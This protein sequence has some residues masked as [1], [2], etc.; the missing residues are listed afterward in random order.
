MYFEGDRTTFISKNANDPIVIIKNTTDD[1]NAARLRL[2]KVRT[3]NGLV[4][5]AQDADK[6]GV[7]E[8]VSRDDGTPD[9]QT[10]GKIVTK[11]ADATSTEESG[12]VELK[13]ATHDG[14]LYNGF[15]LQGGSVAQE[16]DVTIANG[17]ASNTT[18]AG[19]LI[20]TSD[21]TVS[22]TTTTI[23][24]AT[25]QVEDKN[26]VLN[27]NASSDT[28]GTADGAGITIQDAVDAS[29][30]ASLTW[31]SASDKFQFSHPLTVTGDLTVNGE[32]TLF[33]S[34]S[35]GKPLVTIKTTNTTAS[36]SGELRFQKDADNTADGEY[37]GQISFYGE[38]NAGTPE[39]LEY[40]RVIGYMS[41]QIDSQEAGGLYFGVAAYDGVLTQGLLING[42]TNADDEVDVTIGNGAASTTTITGSLELGHASDTTIARSAAGTVTIE[43][44][45]VVTENKQLHAISCSFFDD[46]G[47]TK[48]YIPISSQSTAEQ[49]SDGNTL[50]D[51]LVP[52]STKVKEVMVKLPGTTTGS[53]DLTIGIE[54]S[55]IGASVFSKSIV[56]TETV[57]VAD[58]NDDDIVHFMF[59]DTTHATIGQNLSISI[60]AAS[61]LSSSQNFYIVAI[62]EFD[63][64][65]RHTSGSAIQTS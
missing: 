21:L 60:Q 61:D 25:L 1:A 6:I 48:H 33:E 56:E 30:D 38:N 17:A 47:T 59:D 13:T 31:I 51:F 8:F 19:N 29:N 11:V 7:I 28:S 42:N 23:N 34:S 27:Y 62:L 46:I 24:T 45:Q 36:A 57:A 39:T 63:W 40:A 49:T 10:Y 64:S 5:D 43:G 35:S 9:T 26:I 58:S 50:T 16:V 2:S 44:K 15:T 55:S 52:C 14:S 4:S 20:V 22:G 12:L 37:I 3:T 53:G 65:T 18:I 32:D 41:D 54:T